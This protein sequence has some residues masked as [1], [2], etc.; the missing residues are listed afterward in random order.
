[1]IKR[2]VLK[3]LILAV[4]GVGSDEKS[5]WLFFFLLISGITP[6]Y[7][8]AET[9]EALGLLEKMTVAEQTLN[10]EGTVV[11]QQGGNTETFRHFPRP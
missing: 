6:L 2:I 10:Y 1:M 4:T 3:Q 11:Y 7:V 9:S 5:H 8:Y